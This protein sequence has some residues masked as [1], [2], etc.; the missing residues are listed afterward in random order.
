MKVQNSVSFSS[1][2]AENQRLNQSNKSIN[3][4]CYWMLSRRDVSLC[5]NKQNTNIHIYP[6][7][8]LPLGMCLLLSVFLSFGLLR[9]TLCSVDRTSSIIYTLFDTNSDLSW[10]VEEVRIIP[11]S[12]K[13]PSSS[14]ENQHKLLPQNRVWQLLCNTA[15]YR[16]LSVCMTQWWMQERGY[17]RLLRWMHIV[18]TF[19]WTMCCCN[20]FI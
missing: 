3:R 5:A 19:L 20:D 16:L 6:F 4:W 1:R 15:I 8:P 14:G 18:I 10:W 17:Y 11:V 13:T 12:G 7:F 9:I 2:Q